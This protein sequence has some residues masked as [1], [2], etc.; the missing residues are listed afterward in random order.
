LGRARRFR[1]AHRIIPKPNLYPEPNRNATYHTN[2]TRTTGEYSTR[3]EVTK[4]WN[5]WD[6]SDRTLTG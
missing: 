5:V 2:P 6:Q 4:D 1:Q 3:T